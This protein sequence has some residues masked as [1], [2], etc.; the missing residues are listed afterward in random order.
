MKHLNGTPF[1]A[2]GV[3]HAGEQIYKIMEIDGGLTGISNNENARNRYFLTVPLVANISKDILNSSS[4]NTTPTIHHEN[5]SA[6]QNRQYLLIPKLES[7]LKEELFAVIP[8]AEPQCAYN[9]ITNVYLP[10]NYSKETIKCEEVGREL[11]NNFCKERLGSD[12]TKSIWD[13]VSKAKVKI[14]RTYAK[15]KQHKCNE[16]VI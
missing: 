11:Y 12:P 9:I 4:R 14:F 13:P 8:Y 10:E 1:T 2:I 15:T 16:K 6:F 7:C 3:D 5:T